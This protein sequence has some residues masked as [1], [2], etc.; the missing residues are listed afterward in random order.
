[1]AQPAQVQSIEAIEAFRSALIVYQA[2][3]RAAIEEISAD[4]VRA[5]TWL[6]TDQRRKWEQELR[7]RQRKLEE[8][9]NELFSAQMSSSQ[10]G[11]AMQ[12]MAAK[13]AE[14]AVQ[15]AEAKLALLKKWSHKLPETADPLVK[16][17]EQLLTFLTTD[18]EK[19]AAF[20]AQT[21]KNLDA[22]AAVAP[23]PEKGP[24]A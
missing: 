14:R 18:M 20:L 13:R 22:Y 7:K 9:K 19:A 10:T 17:I 15:E 3:A 5:R 8:A 1:M 23:P 4:M 2:R 11:S 12:F 21:V 6:E 24:S 16:Q